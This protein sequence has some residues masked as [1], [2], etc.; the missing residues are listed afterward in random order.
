MGAH[1]K[2]NFGPERGTCGGTY[3]RTFATRGAHGGH[4]KKKIC[5]ERG[6][7]GAHK[8]EI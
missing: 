6:T 7:W 4:I 8:E 3:R 5:P 1:I 2:R